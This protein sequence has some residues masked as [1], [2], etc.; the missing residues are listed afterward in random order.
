MRRK[1]A[2]GM[3]MG[4]LLLSGSPGVWAQDQHRDQDR[5]RVDR[6][7]QLDRD[8]L[9]DRDRDRDRL[10][11]QDPDRLQ[12]RDRDRDRLHQDL[13]PIYGSELM[14]EQ[15]RNQYRE[16]LRAM[17]SLEEG[18][19]FKAQHREQIQARANEKGVTVEEPVY[20]QQ[21]MTQQERL[22]YREQMRTLQTEQEREQF[23][24]EHREK[25]QTRAQQQTSEPEETEEAE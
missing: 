1:I 6:E 20:G 19:L 24:A 3:V 25:M 14:S 17:Q 8:R 11:G 16:R 13:A 18:E 22:Q 4:S 23:M 5:D 15:E 7:Q 12:T 2:I 9:L 21:L 10:R